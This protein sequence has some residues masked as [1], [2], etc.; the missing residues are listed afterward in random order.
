[1]KTQEKIKQLIVIGSAWQRKAQI[2]IYKFPYNVID[3]NVQ[4]I[5]LSSYHNT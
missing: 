4:I 3:G 2:N 5:M 1:M